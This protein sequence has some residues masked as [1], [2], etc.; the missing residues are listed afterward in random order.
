MALKG[1]E[2]RF[3]M[4]NNGIQK[5]KNKMNLNTNKGKWLCMRHLECENCVFDM[6]GEDSTM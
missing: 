4:Y 1:A 5:S 6:D 2:K 3:P